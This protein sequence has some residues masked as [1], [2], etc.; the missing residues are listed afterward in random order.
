MSLLHADTH[1][2]ECSGRFARDFRLMFENEGFS[3]VFT[4]EQH[5]DIG[6]FIRF[7]SQ[8]GQTSKLQ[9]RL[10]GPPSMQQQ[11]P[12]I[13]P[14]LQHAAPQ[15]WQPSGPHTTGASQY[16]APQPAFQLEPLGGSFLR[17]AS[18]QA[19]PQQW[20]SSDPHR[21]A[22]ETWRSSEGLSWAQRHH[23]EVHG[24]NADEGPN[25]MLGN[26]RLQNSDRQRRHAASEQGHTPL[27]H[28]GADGM[29]DSSRRPSNHRLPRYFEEEPTGLNINGQPGLPSKG[30]KKKGKQKSRGGKRTAALLSAGRITFEEVDQRPGP[31]N[32]DLD[33]QTN[34]AVIMVHALDLR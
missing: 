4:I 10:P 20:H 12:V 17:P 14:A 8:Q 30:P 3:Q 28:T 25:G 5:S 7:I 16:A 31:Q 15:Q 27:S 33:Q 26:S 11:P 6:A 22:A 21:T 23:S 18:Q 19:A 13:T 9:Q 32:G 1:M 29:A 2:H 24:M 34:G